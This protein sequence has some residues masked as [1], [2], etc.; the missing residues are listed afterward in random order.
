MRNFYYLLIPLMILISSCSDEDS[1]TQD[2]KACFDYTP[3][4]DIKPGDEI[5]FTG[6]SE[7]ATTFGWDFGDGDISTEENPIHIY[8]AGG[9]YTVKLIAANETSAD[10]ISQTITIAD[11]GGYFSVNNAKYPLS[12]GALVF[13]N[14]TTRW[15]QL[16]LYHDMDFSL[17]NENYVSGTGNLVFLDILSGTSKYEIVGSYTNNTEPFDGTDEDKANMENLTIYN[18][19]AAIAYNF[20]GDTWKPEENNIVENYEH[21]KYKN[22]TMKISKN[23]SDYTI[24]IS[25]SVGGKSIKVFYQGELE[26]YAD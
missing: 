17:S 14:S 5:S 11:V 15:H 19:F 7:N 8:S 6:C 24:D 20:S 21:D 26:L 23:A 9:D 16:I 3:E 22:W 12:R 13:F 25:F 10:T 4:T 18:G 1:S 2:A